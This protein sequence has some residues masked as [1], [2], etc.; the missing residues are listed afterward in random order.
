VAQKQFFKRIVIAWGL[1]S[2]NPTG[3][4][5]TTLRISSNF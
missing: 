4:M 3:D 5:Q 2:G 1:Y